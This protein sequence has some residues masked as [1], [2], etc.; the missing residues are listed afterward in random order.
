MSQYKVCLEGENVVTVI[1]R[2][3]IFAIDYSAICMR[4]DNT[5]NIRAYADTIRGRYTGNKTKMLEDLP[6][7]LRERFNGHYAL[8]E[9]L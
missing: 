4:E 9:L 5:V 7:S 3:S 2:G 6:C 1:L 8:D